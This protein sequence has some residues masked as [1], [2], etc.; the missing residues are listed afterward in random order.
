MVKNNKIKVKVKKKESMNDAISKIKPDV[1]ERMKRMYELKLRGESL[2]AI[3]KR[4]GLKERMV[5]YYIER[6]RKL[7]SKDWDKQ[8][9]LSKMYDYDEKSRVRVKKLHMIILDSN[10][11]NDEII[12][13]I[14][15]LRREDEAAIKRE[16]LIGIIP[17]DAS[18]LVSISSSS[19]SGDAENKVIINIVSNK[20]K[21]ELGG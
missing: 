6:L 20:D 11:S 5:R 21:K 7:V 2:S 15:E 12:R 3:G 18:P 10:S 16:Q 17:K 9:L 14:K 19:D 4:F 13:S 1:L 8:S